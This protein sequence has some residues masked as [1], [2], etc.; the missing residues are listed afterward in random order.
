MEMIGH[1]HESEQS[2]FA[3]I[4]VVEEHIDQQLGR[5]FTLEQAT[6]SN[7]IGFD[8]EGAF[9]GCNILPI[10]ISRRNRHDGPRG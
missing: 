1:D 8:K 9:S 10:R 4:A 5:P 7:G 6:L 3:S 2:V